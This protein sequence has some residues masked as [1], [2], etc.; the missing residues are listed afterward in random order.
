MALRE[1][2]ELGYVPMLTVSNAEMRGLEELPETDKDLML[3]YF[4]LRPWGVSAE[5][6][7]TVNRIVAAY[8]DRPFLVDI[9]GPTPPNGEPRPV[10]GELAALRNPADGY[11]AWC[12]YV[13]RHALMIPTVQIGDLAQVRAQIQRLY[14]LDRG[15]GLYL[16]RAAH[17]IIGNLAE[18]VG[19]ITNGGEDVLAIIDLGQR[20]QELLLAQAATTGLVRAVIE[21]AP[22]TSIAISASSFP[23]DFV[24]RTEQQIYE[25]QHFNG[26]SAQFTE[27][28]LVYSDRG[29]ARAE[30]QMGGGGPP[31]PRVDL[32]TDGSWSFFRDYTQGPRPAGYAAQ[33]RAAMA[34]EAWDADLRLWGYQMVERTAGN[35]PTAIRSPTSSAAVRINIHLHQQVFYDD[36]DGLY[37]T[38][39]EWTD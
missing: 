27:N 21:A 29:S 8:G 12:D 13:E 38:D 39:D 37:A 36:P 16:P 15:I 32:A 3:P 24:G 20:D 35:D 6:R 25:R 23:Q 5:L 4:Q 34:S 1:F 17:G 2:V 31:A 30:R 11:A 19:E 7:S 10:H 14:A 28:A 26:V 33:A 22:Q 9:C 18:L